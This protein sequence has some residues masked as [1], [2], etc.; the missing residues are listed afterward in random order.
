LY[1]RNVIT[2]I[3]T[4][5]MFFSGGLIPT[6]LVVK[7]LGLLNKIW[8]LILPGAISMYNVIIARTFFQSTIPEEIE[9]S[10][11]IDGSSVT[12]TFIK[13]ILPLSKAII[14]VLALFYAVGHWNSYFDALIYL[15]NRKLYPLQIILREILIENQMKA[16]MVAEGLME[17]S[18][19][20]KVR[21]ASLI[22]YGVIIV[23]S[24]PVFMIYPFIQK[25]FVGGIM[26]GSLKG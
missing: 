6:Y 23:S 21:Y 7:Q 19:I 8:A 2:F 10:A 1:G 12:N 13:I 16:D 17:E 25:Y 22:K 26:I 18:V 4:F 14:S 20:N 24:V 5:T 11:M 9:E 15:T 3:F